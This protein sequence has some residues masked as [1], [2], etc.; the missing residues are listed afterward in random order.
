MDVYQSVGRWYLGWG[1]SGQEVACLSFQCLMGQVQSL[2]SIGKLQL[3][4]QGLYFQ[5]VG[6]EKRAEDKE[7]TC[8]V[9]HKGPYFTLKALQV[10][11]GF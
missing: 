3:L 8:K 10:I 6:S 7:Q 5:P 11:E 9:G 1:E 2:G 4:R